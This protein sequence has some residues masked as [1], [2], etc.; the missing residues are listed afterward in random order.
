[1]RFGETL[2]KMS[3]ANKNIAELRG[4]SFFFAGWL[5]YLMALDDEGV[6]FEPSPDPMLPELTG[7]LNVTELGRSDDEAAQRAARP[8]LSNRAIFGVD[9]FACGLAE[10]V[11]DWFK[12][13]I[14][15]PGAV[16]HALDREFS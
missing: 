14:A 7:Y 4:F 11:M 8:I 3:A 13:F 2:K 5:R 16:R 9:L 10:R 1:V 6:P 12:V 15:S